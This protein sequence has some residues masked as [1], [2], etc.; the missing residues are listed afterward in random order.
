MTAAATQFETAT[1]NPAASSESRMST[2]D[3]SAPDTPLSRRFGSLKG[4]N[5]KP[6]SESMRQFC[7]AYPKPILPQ[8]RTLVNDLIQS[9]HLTT[10]D[11]RFKYDAIFGHGL[12]SVFY[13]LMKAYPGEGEKDKLFKALVSSLDL[14][15]AQL[16]AD[17]EA[18]ASWAK[19]ASEADLAAALKGEGDSQIAT[20]AKGAK[21][22][23]F[24]M[25]SKMWGIG[26]IQLMENCGIE[27][28]DEKLES[29]ITNFGLPAGKAKQDL[30]QYK[31]ILEKSAAAE[32]LFKE[33]EIREKKKMADRLEAKAKAALEA[34]S[35]AEQAGGLN[36][37]ESG[38]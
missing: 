7:E 30:Q 36:K 3:D 14:D 1:V 5:V 6:V 11:A 28:S 27:L 20:V 23:E 34:A 4:K 25:Y 37:H 16:A 2:V 13:K 22:D 15:P 38:N 18:L 24:Y 26:L 33:I 31:D 17:S 8:Y 9:T 10:V 29:L 19:S 21:Q 35:K 32:Q 12:H